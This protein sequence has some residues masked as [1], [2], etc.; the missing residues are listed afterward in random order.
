[1]KKL[2]TVITA[3]AMLC[4]LLCFGTSA[5]G[6]S[7]L[8]DNG[9]WSPDDN[10]GCTCT[11][12][13]AG[14][15]VVFE[16]SQPGT[17]PCT[18]NFFSP[19]ESHGVD[20]SLYAL[21]YDF[22][23]ENG[24]NTNI[25]FYF[26]KDLES[27]DNGCVFTLSNTALGDVSY[28]AGSG[29]LAVGTYAGY[30]PLTEFVA[31]TTLLGSNTF[32]S[33]YID[34]DNKIYFTGVQVYSVSGAKITVYALELVPMTEVPD[35]PSQEPSEESSETP[36]AE[37]SDEPSTEPSDEPS[38]ESETSPA[39][40]SSDAASSEAP[41]SSNGSFPWW[42]VAVIAAVVVIAVVVLVIVKKKK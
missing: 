33:S 3:A 12:T 36:S 17:W 39:D 38:T 26:S 5:E 15:E 24:G 37:P 30:I 20:I 22:I 27:M 10:G 13:F 40:T 16:G 32:D 18:K 34:A 4:V 7:L 35:E 6:L 14:G 19:D 1:M 42:I 9:A 2:I 29:D 11:V 25:S 23:V 21:H 8:P 41:A 31:S 28:D